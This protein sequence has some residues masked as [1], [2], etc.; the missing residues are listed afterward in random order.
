MGRVLVLYDSRTGNTE[1]MALLVAEGARRVEGMEIRIKRVEE[2]TKEDVLWCEGMAVGT[3]T[4]MGIVSWKLKRFFDDVM[5]EL[6]GQID[7]KIGCAFS[8]SGGWGGGS[9]VAC[10]S[11]LYMLIN[12][13]FLV[14]G[15]TD[16]TDRKFTLHYGAVV[17][18]EPRSE[19]EREA[20]L[21]LGKRLAQFVAALYDGRKELLESIRS[22]PGKFPW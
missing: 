7:G 8:S 10:L 15:L 17:A 20:C 12:Y 2:A 4:N 18:G 3:P 1:K 11:V 9:E 22:F 6:W 14:F 13:G 16:Y 5:G 19:E 21:R